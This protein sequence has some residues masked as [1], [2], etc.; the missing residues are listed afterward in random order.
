MDD[1]HL[2]DED[3]LSS[4]AKSMDGATSLEQAAAHVRA[5][6]DQLESLEAK[7]WRLTNPVDDDWGIFRK[8]RVADLS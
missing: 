5:F 8:G 6:A 4:R 7:G 2:D 3:E 1:V